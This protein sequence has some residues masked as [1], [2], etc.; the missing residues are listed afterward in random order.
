MSALRRV[1]DVERLSAEARAAGRKVVF[2]NGCFDIIH[3]GHVEYLAFA[4]GLGD[5]SVA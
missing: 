5:G 2:T 4:R 1:E 3:R